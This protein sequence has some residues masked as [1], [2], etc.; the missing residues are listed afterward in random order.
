MSPRLESTDWADDSDQEL[1]CHDIYR[2]ESMMLRF[3][4]SVGAVIITS[5]W[6]SGPV[7]VHE[8]KR[9]FITCLR[10][11][12]VLSY[13]RSVSIPYRV[14]YTLRNSHFLP[15][16]VVLPMVRVVLPMADVAGARNPR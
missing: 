10:E 3:Q 8:D 5:W 13:S 1:H 4:Y 16:R 12:S 2:I 6:S 15:L 11:L 14:H 9:K 7:Y